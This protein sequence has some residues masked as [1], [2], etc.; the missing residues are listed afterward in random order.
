MEYLVEFLNI[1][2]FIA[3]ISSEIGFSFKSLLKKA[4]AKPSSY[5]N[6]MQSPSCVISRTRLKMRNI[7]TKKNRNTEHI[8]EKIIFIP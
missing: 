4:G 3:S 6:H 2:V 8:L 7:K 1:V 5:A